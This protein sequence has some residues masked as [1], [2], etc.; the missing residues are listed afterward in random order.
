[1]H[2]YGFYGSNAA[3]AQAKMVDMKEGARSIITNKGSTYEGNNMSLH[4]EKNI[5]S[6]IKRDEPEQ[7]TTITGEG[8]TRNNNN[9]H[10]CSP[11][12]SVDR[13]SASEKSINL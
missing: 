3:A 11:Q 5:N 8:T 12:S 4:T 6:E 7:I 13:C 10:C 1:V 2:D 9:C